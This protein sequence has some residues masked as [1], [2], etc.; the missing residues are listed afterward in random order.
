MIRGQSISLLTIEAAIK[1]E[2]ER[3]IDRYAKKKDKSISFVKAKMA[4]YPDFLK[5]VK[6]ALAEDT[7]VSFAYA[8]DMYNSFG[9]ATEV[10]A[11]IGDELD[12]LYSKIQAR[13][14]LRT[15][16]QSS[17]G[18]AIIEVNK[19]PHTTLDVNNVF[20]FVKGTKSDFE[21]TRVVRFAAETETE[22]EIIKERLYERRA[23]SDTHLAFLEQQGFATQYTRESTESFI[24]YQKLRGSGETSRGANQNNRGRAKYRSGY[25]LT[26]GEDGEITEGF[27]AAN[28]NTRY[29][30]TGNQSEK[31]RR[32]SSLFFLTN[33]R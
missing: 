1:A 32:N 20:V 18:E 29:A 21:I 23:F 30:L 3:I 11:F 12:D 22:M 19:K 8:E 26:V 6:F 17:K 13:T 2:N 27:S 7:E 5:G 16:K 28:S 33:D 14:S 24:E 31:E 25:S 9:W 10:G 15:F 4:V